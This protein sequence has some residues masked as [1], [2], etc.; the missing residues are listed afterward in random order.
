VKVTF[1]LSKDPRR[2]ATGDSTTAALLIELARESYETS[3][4]CLSPQPDC[5]SAGYR[6]VLK[7]RPQ[8]ASLLYQSIKRRRSLVHTRFAT[9]A[10]VDA[11]D[12][13]DTD[14]FV[15]I[16]SYMAEAVIRSR[17]YR[18]TPNAASLL[19]VSTEVPEG[20]VW[21]ATRGVVGVV[22]SRRIVRDEVRV[23]REAYSVGAYDQAEVKFYERLGVCRAHWLDVTL[24]PAQR[25]TVAESVPRLVFLGDRTFAPNQQAFQTLLR[26]WP[27]IAEGIP[28]AHLCVVGPSPAE[29]SAALLPDGVQ[30][31][32]FVDNLTEFLGTCRALVAP[33]DTGGGVR[34]KILDAARRGLP[35]VSTR[36]GTGSLGAVLSLESF[37]GEQAIID[38]CRRYLLD[39]AAAAADGGA[40]YDKNAARWH[41]GRP[42]VAV[43]DWLAR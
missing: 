10:L 8:P 15:A 18:A 11:I 9:G 25:I 7:P 26:W 30:N 40:L 21:R 14:V 41:E 36:A 42:H 37:D 23:A 27:R 33:I 22:E 35:V 32:G 38:Q 1:L 28:G 29:L 5:S 16:H 4:I 12:E 6:R 39:P 3:V 19:A 34:V 24:P 17:R 31:L 43:Q 13:A 2:Q 20:P